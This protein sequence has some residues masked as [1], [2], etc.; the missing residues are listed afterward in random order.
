MKKVGPAVTIMDE[1]GRWLVKDVSQ[2][3][4]LS[5]GMEPT[6]QHQD[7]KL[8]GSGNGQSNPGEAQN[9]QLSSEP[10]TVLNIGVTEERDGQDSNQDSG[11]SNEIDNGIY[12][13]IQG[14]NCEPI[15]T[16]AGRITKEP[17][18]IKNYVK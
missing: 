17:N 18:C 16:R 12:K 8:Q 1:N 13:P 3:V 2:L 14:L 7:L 11:R 4:K 6:I 9:I 5:A 10:L 15:M